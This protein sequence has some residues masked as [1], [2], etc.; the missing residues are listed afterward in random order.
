MAKYQQS[1][2]LSDSKL[3]DALAGFWS[4]I[5]ANQVPS[6]LSTLSTDGLAKLV[7][8]P[9]E[10]DDGDY[11]KHVFD[12]V[13]PTGARI[14]VAMAR[15]TSAR[16]PLVGA[17]CARSLV[18]AD[19]RILTRDAGDDGATSEIQEMFQNCKIL[20]AAFDMAFDV[21]GVPGR[22]HFKVLSTNTFNVHAKYFLI[23]GLYGGDGNAKTRQKLVWSG[24]HNFTG[25]ALT[26]NYELLIKNRDKVTFDAF[27][28]EFDSV[29]NAN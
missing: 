13:A 14:D 10:E 6:V 28:A 7:L 12:N 26:S 29:W 5:K 20:L 16:A 22:F 15:W 9:R 2:Y 24:S 19:V 25:K 4:T 17:L 11:V 23:D 8:F 3:F 1:A 18:G 27:R 21:P